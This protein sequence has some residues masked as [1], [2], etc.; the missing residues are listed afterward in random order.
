MAEA[1]NVLC[2]YAWSLH[3]KELCVLTVS[4]LH[5]VTVSVLCLMT[6]NLLCVVIADVLCMVIDTELC[7]M[8]ETVETCKVSSSNSTFE[9]VLL[10]V[11]HVI[12]LCKECVC[13]CP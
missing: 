7:V 2:V 13:C 4:V 3:A 6:A 10:P 8:V 5:V 12:E 11:R 1:A 9:H